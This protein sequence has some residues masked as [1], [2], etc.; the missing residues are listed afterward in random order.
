MRW[1]P[2]RGAVAWLVRAPHRYLPCIA[3]A[4]PPARS[5]LPSLYLSDAVLRYGN[6]ARILT[7]YAR[8]GLGRAF[9]CRLTAA[10]A[11]RAGASRTPT[12]GNVHFAAE[13]HLQRRRQVSQAVAAVMPSTGQ[14]G[15]LAHKAVRRARRRVAAA[16]APSG[17]PSASAHSNDRSRGRMPCQTQPSRLWIRIWSQKCRARRRSPASCSQVRDGICGEPG[18]SGPPPVVPTA[19]ACA[20]GP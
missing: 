17:G 13:R 9:R 11:L 12:M 19:I 14:G 18:M 4:E 10:L 8:V 16:R 15:A 7:S 6:A 5:S 3:P 2:E 20:W 1:T